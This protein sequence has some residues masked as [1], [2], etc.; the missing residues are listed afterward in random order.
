MR[1]CHQTISFITGSEP[2]FHSYTGYFSLGRI[3][4]CTFRHLACWSSPI[5]S[6]SSLPIPP[7]FTQHS[8]I[9]THEKQRFMDMH[10]FIYVEMRAWASLLFCVI[11]LPAELF[12]SLT[13]KA[14]KR[15]P[16]IDTTK[17]P[18]P[19]LFSPLFPPPCAQKNTGQ[20]IFFSLR[21][22]ERETERETTECINNCHQ[23]PIYRHNKIQTG[24]SEADFL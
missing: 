21:M 13:H 5:L 22:R 8:K 4:A 1:L 11:R 12:I 23:R 2:P 16:Y 14:C 6:F 20:N 3:F 10:A 7:R 18:L 9:F 24:P 15:K 17:A 19:S